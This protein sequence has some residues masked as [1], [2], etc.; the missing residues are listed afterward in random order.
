MFYKGVTTRSM[1]YSS[2]ISKDD[3]NCKILSRD[4]TMPDIIKV[5]GKLHIRD[6][7]AVL[8]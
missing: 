5:S 4:Q 8:R 6:T 2:N 3:I 7:F 1:I